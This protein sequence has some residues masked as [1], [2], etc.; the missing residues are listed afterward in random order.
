MVLNFMEKI[1]IVVEDATDLTQEIIEKYQIITVP[2]KLHWPEI[3]NLPGENTF[4]KVRELE[5]QGI[6]SFGK[7]SQPSMKEFLDAYNF[8]LSRFDKVICPTLTSKHSGSYNSAVQGRNFLEP[9]KQS[10][11]FVIDSQN[12]SCSQGLIILKLADLIQGGKKAEE[13]V[14]ELEEFIPKVHLYLMLEDPKWLEA[15]GRITPLVASLI[16]GMAKR[17]IRLLLTFKKGKLTPAGIKIGVEDVPAALFKQ[18]E[19]ETKKIITEGNKVRVAISHG[20]WPEGAQRLREMIEKEKNTEI[21]FLNI[22][23]NVIGAITG[24]NT[25]VFAWYEL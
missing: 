13:I 4:Q 3:E 1:G 14:K 8:Q 24:P 22:L 5:K 7:T 11:V 21:A 25:M 9:E 15:S 18:F 2:A 17:G 20:D 6:K 19:S 12:A 16:R 23:G 10:K